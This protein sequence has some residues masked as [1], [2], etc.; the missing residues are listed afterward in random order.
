M[1]KTWFTFLVEIEM[2]IRKCL[3]KTK[4]ME[5]NMNDT[6]I[7]QHIIT[8]NEYAKD[9]NKL[10]EETNKPVE[11]KNSVRQDACSPSTFTS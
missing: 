10:V 6:D 11:E 3:I 9:V 8:N 1:V 2:F 5:G 7:K 4:S